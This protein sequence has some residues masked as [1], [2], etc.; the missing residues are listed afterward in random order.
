MR[1]YAPGASAPA[2]ATP[3][4]APAANALQTVAGQLIPYPP[5]ADPLLL[6]RHNALL[7]LAWHCHAPLRFL[8][9]MPLPTNH[10]VFH[11]KH[12]DYVLLRAADDPLMAHRD[13]Y[14]VPRNDLRSLER[15][16]ACGLEFDDIYIAHE[17]IPGSVSAGAPVPLAALLPPV[18]R[19]A[20][21]LA[22]RIG[23]AST[24]MAALLV[25]PLLGAG[26]AAKLTVGSAGA[27]GAAIGLDPVILGVLGK[28]ADDMAC[29][30]YL[31]HW[32]YNEDA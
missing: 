23:Q 6:D 17:V 28:P 26:A 24:T 8:G 14:P 22:R 3:A 9:S 18:S 4:H 1:S 11:G 7:D 20:Q 16:S 2:T 12:S 31:R 25:R 32:V 27:L 10:C 29:W 13:G 21:L 15:M 30:Y 19:R 5:I